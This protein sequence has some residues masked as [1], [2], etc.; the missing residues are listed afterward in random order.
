MS[1]ADAPGWTPSKFMAL[2]YREQAGGTIDVT[3]ADCNPESAT[4]GKIVEGS[5]SLN[6]A[7]LGVDLASGVGVMFVGESLPIRKVIS[8][9]G[10]PHLTEQLEPD[11]SDGTKIYSWSNGVYNTAG[12]STSTTNYTGV[13]QTNIKDMQV[14]GI[15]C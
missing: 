12:M 14:N 2:S 3:V 4:C 8:R 11:S 5:F 10:V 15:E 13:R 7:D 9:M 6:K 1:Y